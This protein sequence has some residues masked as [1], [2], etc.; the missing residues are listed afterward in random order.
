MIHVSGQHAS[1]QSFGLG[2]PVGKSARSLLWRLVM[3]YVLASI[4]AVVIT[5][6]LVLI[7]LQFSARQWL[8]LF[9]VL[10]FA[11]MLYLFVDVYMIRRHFEPVGVA[12]AKLDAGDVPSKE[13]ASWAIVRA[14]NLPFYSFMRVTFVHGPL[15][16]ISVITGLLIVDTF[17]KVQFETWQIATFAATVLFFA[18]PTHAIY[19]YFAISHDVAP[20]RHH[21]IWNRSLVKLSESL[22]HLVC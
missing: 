16:T 20:V 15:A 10:P 11:L 1:R 2:L 17:F 19:E 14:L 3:V 5:F 8:G 7:G 22:A 4:A 13:E 12:L 21:S 18:A 6:F 9:G